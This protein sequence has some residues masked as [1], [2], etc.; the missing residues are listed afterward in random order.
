MVRAMKI[1]LDIEDD[2]LNAAK[3]VAEREHKTLT[4]WVEERLRVRLGA[5][6][7]TQSRRPQLLPVYRG[8]S[9]LAKGIDPTTLR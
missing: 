3:A 7:R 6:M 1:T 2:L 9:G 4:A 8:K 5:Q